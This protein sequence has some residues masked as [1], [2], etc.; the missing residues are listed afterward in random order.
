M[1]K[2]IQW[3]ACS[4][5]VLFVGGIVRADDDVTFRYK[6]TADVKPIYQTTKT[7]EQTQTI[8]GQKIITTMKQSRIN[9]WTL[10][11]TDNKGN[12]HF[13]T[14]TQQLKVKLKIDPVG[15]YEFD[16]TADEQERGS[17][18][19]EAL[20]PIYDRLAN[21]S[22][23]VTLSPL[24]EVKT[25]GG[26]QKLLGDLLKDNP[27]G[28]QLAGGGSEDAAKLSFSEGFIVFSNKPVKPGDSWE[29]EFNI[30]LQGIGM[31]KGKRIYQYIGPDKVGE[32]VTA[33]FTMTLEL[34][35][36]IDIKANGA[37][38]TGSL[39]AN[40]SSGTVQFDPELGRVVSMK[41]SYTFGGDITVLANG[42]SQAISTSQ[43]QT[44]ERILLDKLPK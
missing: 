25:V 34:S 24:G 3:L 9:Q 6:P 44:V 26:H 39:A 41:A 10:E 35:I 21:A 14:E 1:T 16:S 12:F 29:T 19:S 2:K 23:T 11:K 36:D 31:A 13:L 4:L 27:L 33:K 40:N 42:V 18:L 32:V 5:S 22:L 15:E 7:M 38:I 20:G 17:V 37:E 8:A 28:A 30:E 43:T